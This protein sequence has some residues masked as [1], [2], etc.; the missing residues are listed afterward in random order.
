MYVFVYILLVSICIYKSVP[1]LWSLCIILCVCIIIIPYMD[2]SYVC[3]YVC[4]YI[5]M[6]IDYA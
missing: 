1:I 3:M 4:M 6:Y 5:C 2:V